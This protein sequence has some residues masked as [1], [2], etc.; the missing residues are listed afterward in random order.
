MYPE[1]AA[2]VLVFSAPPI[3]PAK[4]G[5]R[6]LDKMTIMEIA[7]SSSIKVKPRRED[8]FPSEATLASV[9][10]WLE[11]LTWV[12]AWYVVLV[13]NGSAV[14]VSGGPPVGSFGK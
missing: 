4:L 2:L 10:C 1:K 7:I 11:L 3:K 13:V 9:N 6:M 14:F 12:I 5:M 8:L